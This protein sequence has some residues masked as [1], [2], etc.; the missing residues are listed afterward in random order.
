[1]AGGRLRPRLVPARRFGSPS[2]V[3]PGRD[4]RDVDLAVGH[5]ADAR[6]EDDVRPGI[7]RGADLVRRLSD[8]AQAQIGRAG[9]MEQDAVGTVDARLEQ[10]ARC[11]LTRCLD[12]A[13]L[14]APLTEPD[15]RRSRV[16]DDRADVGEV[17]VDETRRRQQLDDALDGLE[18]HLVDDA[19]RLERRRLGVDDLGDVVVRD[20]DHRVDLGDQT[21]GRFLG[22]LTTWR[23]FEIEGLGHDG[24][25][26][27]A[28]LAGL[29][30]DD[31][32]GTRPGPAA[33]TGSDEHE[34]GTRDRLRD[35]VGILFG[36]PSAGLRVAAGAKPARHGIADA[37]T[38]LG[39]GLTEG[40]GIGVDGD[41]ADTR[42][43]DIDHAVDRVAAAT[44]DADHEDRSRLGPSPAAKPA[45]EGSEDPH[46]Q[47]S[48]QDDDDELDEGLGRRVHGP[49]V[50][51]GGARAARLIVLGY[52]VPS[53][54]TAFDAVAASDG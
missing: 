7:D 1:M 3:E 41:E 47:E 23:P 15:Q 10:R 2:T 28:L 45:R 39:T 16:L 32:R 51:R 29:G 9:D 50:V 43:P 30:C 5:L 27:C 17:E 34:V 48:Q 44:A 14:A 4:Q 36:G 40:L 42:E 22:D 19:E 37:Q 11:R 12:R 6:A 8:L 25:R 52:V 18:E 35:A 53:A 26:Q 13:L 21:L 46:R 33:E 31:R 54:V 20:G 38:N 24:D 49:S